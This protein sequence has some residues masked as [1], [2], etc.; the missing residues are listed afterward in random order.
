MEKMPAERGG[1]KLAIQGATVRERL[2]VR[3]TDSPE[4]SCFYRYVH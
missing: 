3:G 1:L 4:S 2:I